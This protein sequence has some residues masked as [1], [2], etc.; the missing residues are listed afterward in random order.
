MKYIFGPYKYSKFYFE[1][2]K[3]NSSNI[4]PPKALWQGELSVLSS[5]EASGLKHILLLVAL[6]C[7]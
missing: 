5:L 4:S 2:E 3:K 1:F 6:R 7:L